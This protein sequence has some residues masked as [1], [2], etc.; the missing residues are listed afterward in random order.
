MVPKKID[1]FRTKVY[2]LSKTLVLEFSGF[3]KL[4]SKPQQTRGLGCITEEVL[5]VITNG[6][7]RPV[8]E[9]SP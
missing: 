5:R 8:S 7:R 6:R 1:K 2:L 9:V 4:P 3:F